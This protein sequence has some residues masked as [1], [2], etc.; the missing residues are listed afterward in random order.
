[1]T[2]AFIRRILRIIP[3]LLCCFFLVLP[4]QAGQGQAVPAGALNRVTFITWAPFVCRKTDRMRRI[5]IPLA[6]GAG[7]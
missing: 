6:G 7:L 1:M 5:S 3:M 4:A 2:H